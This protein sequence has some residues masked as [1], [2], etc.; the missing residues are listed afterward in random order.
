MIANVLIMDVVPYRLVGVYDNGGV[1]TQASGANFATDLA[2]LSAIPASTGLKLAVIYADGET[3]SAPDTNTTT[4]V[5]FKPDKV[6]T[7]SGTITTTSNATAQ[8]SSTVTGVCES[9]FDVQYQNKTDYHDY[10]FGFLR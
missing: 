10:I 9:Q 3:L 4:E 6:G 7:Y 8:D 2:L 5:T 1:W